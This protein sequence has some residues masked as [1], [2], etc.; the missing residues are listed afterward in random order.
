MMNF[1]D[2]SLNNIN[3]DKNILGNSLRSRQGFTAYSLDKIYSKSSNSDL[4]FEEID[5]SIN[6]YYSNLQYLKNTIKKVK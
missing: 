2:K 3:F 1:Y 4:T 6:K 5:E